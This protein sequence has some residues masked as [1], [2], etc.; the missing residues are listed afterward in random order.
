M[1]EIEYMKPAEIENRSMEIISA[2]L[3]EAGI[4]LDP[5]NETVIKRCIHTSADFSYAKTLRFSKDAVKEAVRLLEQGCHI[6]TDTNMALSGINKHAAKKLNIQL[7]CFM[8]DEDVA[9]EAK[10]RG[11]TRAVVSMEKAAGL[12]GPVMFAV[13]NAPTALICLY[14]MMQQEKYMPAF[15]IGVPVGFVN[16]EA[17]KERIMESPAPFIVNKGRKGGS[18]IAAAIVNSLM[19]SIT[20]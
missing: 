2:E 8:A 6:V 13:G 9:K 10:E 12:D 19:Y 16:V 20:R 5:K 15:I 7:H 17:S 4:T 1:T 3:L 11:V 14:D 18:N